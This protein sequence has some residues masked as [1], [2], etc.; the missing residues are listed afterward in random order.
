MIK[1]GGPTCASVV[2]TWWLHRKADEDM[3]SPDEVV[4]LTDKDWSVIDGELCRVLQFEPLSRILA[5]EIVGPKEIPYASVIL[6]C[7]KLQGPVRGYVTHKID[8][9]NLWTVFQERTLGE[10]EEVIIVWTKQH[11]KTRWLKYF[12]KVFPKLIV[13]VYPKGHLEVLENPELK[14]A[15]MSY[16]DVFKPITELKPDVME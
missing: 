12:S 6:E 16:R 8:F 3:T 10:D 2:L 5:G 13:M 4:L 9:T 1:V 14:P 11:Y 7:K 15:S